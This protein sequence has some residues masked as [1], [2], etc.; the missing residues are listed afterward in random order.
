MTF[1]ISQA[2]T[3][4]E[5]VLDS[6]FVL[7]DYDNKTQD[8]KDLHKATMTIGKHSGLGQKKTNEIALSAVVV[9]IEA[10]HGISFPLDTFWGT[11]GDLTAKNGGRI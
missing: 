8:L 11:F 6:I 2:E 1:T 4:L 9:T 7:K 10:G 5:K 3:L